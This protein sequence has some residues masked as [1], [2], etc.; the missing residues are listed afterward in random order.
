RHDTNL[1]E[2]PDRVEQDEQQAFLPEALAL[3]VL[4]RP[5]PVPDEGHD[6]G[7]DVPDD[8]RRQR[9]DAEPAVQRVLDTEL[10]RETYAAH[11]SE[12]GDLMHKHL[13]PDV[14]VADQTHL[15]SFLSRGPRRAPLPSR[16]RD[17]LYLTFLVQLPGYRGGKPFGIRHDARYSPSGA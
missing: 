13:K 15:R 10:T 12:L 3:A 11:D 6:R 2:D 5:V 16:C 1:D 4:E 17:L 8:Q 9:A 14:V 7:D